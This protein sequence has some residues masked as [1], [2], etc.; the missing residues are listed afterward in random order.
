MKKLPQSLFDVYALALPCGHGF[1]SAPPI[2]AWQSYDDSNDIFGLLAA[3]RRTDQTWAILSA[4][5]KCLDYPW[6]FKTSILCSKTI[7][8]NESEPTLEIG[9]LYDDC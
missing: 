7:I 6:R 8:Q 9:D 3:R 4:A 5:R 2:A 1:G